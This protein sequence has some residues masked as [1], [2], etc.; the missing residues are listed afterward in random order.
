MPTTE[1]KNNLPQRSQ[2]FIKWVLLL[3][4]ALVLAQYAGG[5]DIIG[6]LEKM[7]SWIIDVVNFVVRH[8][9]A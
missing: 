9:N 2:G 5:V 6:L 7:W 8:I 3:V 1:N 4:I